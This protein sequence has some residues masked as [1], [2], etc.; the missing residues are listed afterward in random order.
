MG[1]S[2]P[3]TPKGL[4]ASGRRVW[5][6]TFAER[7]DGSRLELRPD[8]V[9][10]LVELCRLAD[11]VERLRDELDDAPLMIEGSKGQDVAHPL[12]AELHRTSTR[13][14]SIQKTLAIPDDAGSSSS[15]AGRSLARARWS[16]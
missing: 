6:G 1:D 3:K 8:E 14:E 2:T 13:M 4:G 10:L 5:R 9:P 12:R 16:A 11:D 7:P 15:W